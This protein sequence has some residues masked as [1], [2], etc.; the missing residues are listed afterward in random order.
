MK[1]ITCYL[2]VLVTEG[3]QLSKECIAAL[4][5]LQDPDVAKLL[6]EFSARP[7]CIR[8]FVL[9]AMTASEE[10]RAGFLRVIDALGKTGYESLRRSQKEALAEFEAVHFG[11]KPLY[12]EIDRDF[13]ND[14]TIGGE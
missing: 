7:I 5:A 13:I 3:G 6:G 10:A 14:D 2:V 8:D 12:D 4:I 9:S 1:Q 11:E